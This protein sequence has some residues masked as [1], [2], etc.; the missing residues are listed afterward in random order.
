MEIILERGCVEID[1]NMFSLLNVITNYV[2]RVTN[3]NT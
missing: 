1:R 2:N 3:S